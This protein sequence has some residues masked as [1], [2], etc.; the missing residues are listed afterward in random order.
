MM[1]MF[2]S[3]EAENYLYFSNIVAQSCL[4]MLPHLLSWLRNQKLLISVFEGRAL[5]CLISSMPMTGDSST[6]LIRS[7][8]QFY[9]KDSKKRK[10]KSIQNQLPLSAIW[11]HG[12]FL[13]VLPWLAYN[14]AYLYRKLSASFDRFGTSLLWG[15][16]AFFKLH[17]PPFTLPPLWPTRV[18][19]PE[20]YVYLW[21]VSLWAWGG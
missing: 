17:W 1:S 8:L 13:P 21:Q 12:F 14:Q 15:P 3:P 11:Q 7:L 18:K 2:N 19:R 20:R 5:G 10:T 6:K 9:R 16:L 4:A